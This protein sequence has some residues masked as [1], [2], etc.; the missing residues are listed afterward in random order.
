M[1]QI[2]QEESKVL[3]FVSLILLLS[4]SVQRFSLGNLLKYVNTNIFDIFEVDKR[5]SSLYF[6]CDETKCL[7]LLITLL[8][9][10]MLVD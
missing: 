3:N 9:E 1:K 8:C 10:R 5:R 4:A 7:V 2:I 6:D